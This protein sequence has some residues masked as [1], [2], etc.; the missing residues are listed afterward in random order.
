MKALEL[1]K[2]LLKGYSVHEK[3]IK[4][5]IE[6]LEALQEPKTCDGCKHNRFGSGSD[7]IAVDCMVVGYG[8]KRG[9]WKD[10]YEPKDKE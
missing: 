5:A 2:H 7:G 1:L 10:Y 8:C 6:E 9:L 4:E 3:N